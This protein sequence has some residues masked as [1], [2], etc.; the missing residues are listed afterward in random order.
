MPVF[1]YQV[2]TS[3]SSPETASDYHLSNKFS[4]IELSSYSKDIADPI[5]KK[6]ACDRIIEVLTENGFDYQQAE[7]L[8]NNIEKNLRKKDPSMKAQYVRF[9]NLMLDDIRLLHRE[10]YEKSTIKSI[11]SH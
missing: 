7:N 11:S 5:M 8:A 3:S 10:N 2:S 1:Y 6:I 9:F 4:S